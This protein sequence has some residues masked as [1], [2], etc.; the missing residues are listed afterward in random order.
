MTILPLS[1]YTR[2]AL[3]EEYAQAD[4]PARDA[5]YLDWVD[6]YGEQTAYSLV[7]LGRVFAIYPTDPSEFR[8]LYTH[9]SG[10]DA[11]RREAVSRLSDDELQNLSISLRGVFL[12]PGGNVNEVWHLAKQMAGV[13]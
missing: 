8:T 10:M 13:A 5:L 1:P 9:P 3:G 4:G 12:A 11:E 6:R 7:M 2:D